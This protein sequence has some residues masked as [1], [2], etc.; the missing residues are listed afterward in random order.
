MVPSAAQTGRT[1]LSSCPLPSSPS[2]LEYLCFIFHLFYS[3]FYFVQG[4]LCPLN[5]APLKIVPVLISLCRCT[6]YSLGEATFSV[7]NPMYLSRPLLM[8]LT[9]PLARG[10]A[11]VRYWHRTASRTHRTSQL[12]AVCLPMPQDCP[13][14]PGP[15]SN[16]RKG[17]QNSSQNHAC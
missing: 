13:Q 2:L 7:C 11:P 3:A 5:I 16:P 9:D 6:L 10:S 8:C 1:T 15:T 17:A 4:R 14:F 12:A